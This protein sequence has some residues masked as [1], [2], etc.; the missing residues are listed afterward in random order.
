VTNGLLLDRPGAFDAIRSAGAVAVSVDGLSES[1]DRLRG[2]R[3]AF[4]K[5]L[6]ALARLRAEGIPFAISCGVTPHNIGELDEL[7]LA[8]L[9]AGANALQLHPVELAGRAKHHAGDNVLDEEGATAFF[10]LAH[11]LKEEYADRLAIAVDAA[12]RL[13][14]LANPRM[15]YAQSPPVALAWHR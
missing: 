11:L 4:D 1:H 10:V 5:T 3:R 2:R 13:T 12:H 6:T 15:L 9:Q 7:A 14:V 8:A